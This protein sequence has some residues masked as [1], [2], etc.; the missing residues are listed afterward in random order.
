[1][2]FKLLHPAGRL[3]FALNLLLV[4][5]ACNAPVVGP[6]TAPIPSAGTPAATTAPLPTRVVAAQSTIAAEGSLALATPP[7]QLSFDVSARI[8]TVTVVAGQ[9][10][11]QGDVLARVDDNQLK[12]ALQQAKDQLELTEAQIR[13]S[14]AP[15]KQTDLDSARAAL[16]SAV[17]RYN[18]LKKGP[19]SSEIEQAM[20]N[21]NQA[22][23]SLYSAQ[24]SRDVQCGWSAAQPAVDKITPEDPECKQAQYNVSS[25]ELSEDISRLRYQDAQQP[26]SQEKLAQAYADVV[27][28]RA[29]LVKLEAGVTEQQTLVAEVQLAQSRVAVTRAERNLSKA[30][31]I[32]P[33]DCTVQEVSIVPGAVSAPGTTAITLLRL[34]NIRFRTT[35]LTERDITDVEINASV[36]VRLRAYERTFTGK[37]RA[38]LPQAS[39][40]QGTNA[41]FTAIIELDPASEVLL[42]GMTGQAN[43]EVKS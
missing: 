27:S 26:P 28:A 13:Q 24:I 8:L 38:I 16:N 11:K 29:N 22:K 30:Q 20:R 7:L 4:L 3:A 33:C 39:G 37:V 40:T 18:E 32:S 19:S 21:W 15:A 43:I 1:M 12:D 35:N 25:A 42:P 10:V 31:L 5:T 23:N 41:L 6:G 2:G 17:A 9:R 34:D 36:E 14:Q